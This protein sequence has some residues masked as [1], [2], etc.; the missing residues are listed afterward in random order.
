MRLLV[1]SDIRLFRDGLAALLSRENRFTIVGAAASASELR[2]TVIATPP[3]V[4]LVDTAMPDALDAVRAIVKQ[5]ANVKI[6]T[7]GLSDTE[8]DLCACAEAGVSGFVPRHGSFEDL[9]ETL[10]CVAR[11]ELRCSGRA[12]A[13]LLR[14]VTKLATQRPRI[15]GGIHLTPRE[16]EVL[17]LIDQGQSNKE[18]AASLGIEVATAKNHV[19]NILEKLHVHRRGEAAARFRRRSRTS[20]AELAQSSPG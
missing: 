10:E 2:E 3:E 7:V 18:I 19:H 8:R 20:G 13:A 14:R 16:F 1:A 15:S 5:Q 17:D 4:V 6:V 9:V 11:G 12:A